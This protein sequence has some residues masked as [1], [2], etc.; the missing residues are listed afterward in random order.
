MI[1]AI[2]LAAMAALFF[3]LWLG[4]RTGVVNGP[5]RDPDDAAQRIYEA[6]HA[7][8]VAESEAYRWKRRALR[9][10]WRRDEKRWDR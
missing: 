5:V 2:I 9:L 8:W 1:A 7:R 3:G 10:G 6:D 4:Y